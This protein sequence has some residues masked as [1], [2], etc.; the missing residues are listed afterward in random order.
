[1]TTASRVIKNT[2]YLYAK[3]G[4]TMFVSLYTTRLLL[5]SLGA[6]D[7]GIFNVVGGAIAMLGFLNAAMASATQRFMSYSEGEGDKEKQ[8]KI[9]NISVLLHFFVAIAIGI[10]LFA[11]GYFFFDGVLNI[12]SDRIFAAR[13]I[14]YCMIASTMF[15]VMT[16]P[17]DAVLNAHE[18]MLYYAIVGIVESFLKL[19]VAFAVVYTLQDKLI[20]YGILMAVI[21]FVV[22]LIMRIYC[23]RKYA[24]CTFAPKRYHDKKLMKEMARFA[25]WSFLTSS[26]SMISQYGMS[27]VLNH[28]W[29]VILNAAQAIA[30]Q[31]GGQLMVFSNTMMKALNPV[32]AK[33]EGSGNR[34]KMVNAS[35]LGARFS[36]LSLAVFAIPFITEAPFILKIWLTNIPDWAILFVRLQ[37]IRSLTELLTI[38]LISGIGAYGDIRNFSIWKSILNVLPIILTSLFFYFHF[39]PYY[40]YIVWIFFWSILGGVLTLY[41]SKIKYNLSYKDYCKQVLLPT[42]GVTIVMVLV[43]TILKMVIPEGLN[44]LILVCIGAGF[45]GLFSYCVFFITQQE[46]FLFAQTITKMKSKFLTKKSI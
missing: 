7:F 13:I 27:I 42:L 41:F 23:H 19:I 5:N 9:F 20:I 11:C 34:D 37:L 39:P 40:L 21:S 17:Y 18:N 36:Y 32:I 26:S 1:M 29:G 45:L 22:M 33:S 24:E 46:K 6:S 44:R 43:G 38:A 15:T 30:N 35:L 2:G 4:I 8:K 10:L 12:A 14:Y 25:G 16:V 31:I 3:M 28:F